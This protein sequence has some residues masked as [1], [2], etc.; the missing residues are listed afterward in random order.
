MVPV[1]SVLP[2]AEDVPIPDAHDLV[3]EFLTDQVIDFDESLADVLEIFA[4]TSGDKKRVKVDET[5]T[6]DED[7]KHF[8]SSR[9]WITKF[10]T[11]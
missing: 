5:K 7:R 4:V 8:R 10:S 2:G 9:G 6:T 11:I 3:I 1:P